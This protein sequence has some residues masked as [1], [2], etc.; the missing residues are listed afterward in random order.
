MGEKPPRLLLFS[1]KIA[2][3]VKYIDYEC[4]RQ[5]NLLPGDIALGKGK[6]GFK[7]LSH[8]IL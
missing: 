1:K 7:L 3:F 4:L 5:N 8:T 6:L 2:R